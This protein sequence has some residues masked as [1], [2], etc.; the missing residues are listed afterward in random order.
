MA[1]K[2]A[3]FKLDVGYLM[4][5]KVAAVSLES[6]TAVLL[7]IGSIAYSAQ[8]LTDGIV[9]I[10]L[11]LRLTGATKDDAS[12]LMLHGL[13]SD[14]GDGAAEVHDFLEHQ[15]SSADVK[16]S[17]DKA[18]KAATARWTPSDDAS[19][20]AS[21][22]PDALQVASD[23]AM[24]R[25]K[26]E[27][28]RKNTRT[29]AAPARFEE[30]W[31]AYPKR[32][33]KGHARTAYTKALKKT[34]DETLI[35][36]AKRYAAVQAGGDPKFTALPTTWLNGERWEDDATPAA[37]AAIPRTAWDRPYVGEVR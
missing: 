24:P 21:S 8:H 33:D 16:H 5:P 22:M 19:S 4:N 6:S 1:D 26:R 12:L 14:A 32:V 18:R 9:P 31:S 30:F 34:D 11:L 15:R 25:E 13:W 17:T 28:E 10:A 37:S 23:E 2:R 36:G 29:P 35:A 20:N 3:Y 27:R 7:H